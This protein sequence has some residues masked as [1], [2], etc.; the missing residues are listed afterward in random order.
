[1]TS[2]AYGRLNWHVKKADGSKEQGSKTLKKEQ[3]T[4]ENPRDIGRVVVTAAR[5]TGDP[6]PDHFNSVESTVSVEV[7]YQVTF[8]DG[9]LDTGPLK[10]ALKKARSLA[11]KASARYSERL[12]EEM[13]T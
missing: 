5:R 3:V 4:T 10:A 12:L 2:Q 6:R 13:L 7:P 9:T 11:H 1:M 8:V